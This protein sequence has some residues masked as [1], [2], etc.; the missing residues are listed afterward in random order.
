MFTNEQLHSFR[1]PHLHVVE[2]EEQGLRGQPLEE[3]TAVHVWWWV[4]AVVG[5]GQVRIPLKVV[6]TCSN[7]IKRHRCH[8][9]FSECSIHKNNHMPNYTSLTS[10]QFAHT[11]QKGS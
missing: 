3:F 6:P 7:T 10:F 8:Q 11:S 2:Y 4:L 5:L 1:N 9:R